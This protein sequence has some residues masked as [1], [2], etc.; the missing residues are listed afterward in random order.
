M[1]SYERGTP[2]VLNFEQPLQVW[3]QRRAALEFLE[4]VIKRE[5][6]YKTNNGAAACAWLEE[7]QVTSPV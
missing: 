4:H 2:E 3:A 1:V 6:E 7:H 5:K